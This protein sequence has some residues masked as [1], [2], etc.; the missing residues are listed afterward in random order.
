[1]PDARLILLGPPRLESPA[2]SAPLTSRKGLAALAYLAL[3]DRAQPRD[4]LADLFWPDRTRTDGL[5]NLRRTLYR[6]RAALPHQAL[7]DAGGRLRLTGRGL[8]VDAVAF[9]NALRSMPAEAGDA[10][11]ER[12]ALEGAIA[13]CR[14]GLLEG[15]DLRDCEAFQE[16]CRLEREAHDHALAAA[17]ER[18]GAACLRGGDPHAALRA[19]RRWAT[20]SP[21]SEAAHRLV[22]RAQARLGDTPAALGQ[23]RRL[24]TA[25]EAELGATPDPV[26]EALQRALRARAPLPSEA[27]RRAPEEVRYA[28]SGGVH[29][30]FQVIGGGPT[31]VLVAPGFVSHLDHLWRYPPLRAALDRLAEGC[32]LIL[33]DRRGVGLSERVGAPPTLYATARDIDAVLGAAGSSG[34]VLFGFSEGGPAALLYAALRPER[35]RALALYGT[36]AKGLQAPDY[37]PAPDEAQFDRWLEELVS[38]WGRPVAHEAFAPSYRDEPS[39]WSWYAEMMRLGS[40]PAGMRAILDAVRRLDVRPLLARVHTPTLLAHRRGDRVIRVGAGRYLAERLPAARYLELDGEDHWWWLGDAE[41]FLRPLK[42]FIAEAASRH[43]RSPPLHTVLWRQDRE[44]NGEAVPFAEPLAALDATDRTDLQGASRRTGP[45][46]VHCALPAADPAGLARRLASLARPGEIVVTGRVR[47]IALSV[48][49][50]FGPR[51]ALGAG[52]AS[53]PVSAWTLRSRPG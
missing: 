14:G 17:L 39:L 51:D 30:A 24:R 35:V 38:R 20:L 33:F 6:V 37:D 27:A 21:L 46:V 9:R 18:L 34:A 50:G 40:S 2:A 12:R 44:G 16:W 36:M 11:A 43:W 28:R 1:M 15:F 52:T 23:Y 41:A 4:V 29:I 3:T 42:D 22:M 10:D 8:W 13:L 26:T 47:D 31:D 5:T 53:A 19:G 49:Y 45:A 7:E 32:R 25:L 48:G